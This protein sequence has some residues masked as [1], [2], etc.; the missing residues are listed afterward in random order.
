MRRGT[1]RALLTATAVVSLADCLEAGSDGSS[2][3][4]SDTNSD[5]SSDSESE[6]DDAS[7]GRSDENDRTLPPNGTVPDGSPECGV[8]RLVAS[9]EIDPDRTAIFLEPSAEPIGDG[10]RVT[11]ELHNRSEGRFSHDP[12]RWKVHK[13]VG[14]R[15]FDVGPR[16]FPGPDY[17]LE[18]DADRVR[19]VEPEPSSIVERQG[20]ADSEYDDETDAVSTRELEG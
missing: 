3:N 15:W 6:A 9:R 18:P 14:G 13:H 12:C 19:L 20:D 1:R 2:E 16:E 7:E 17:R 8:D 11:F 5:G 4:G 10:D